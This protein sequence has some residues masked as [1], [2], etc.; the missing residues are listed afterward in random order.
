MASSVWQGL[1]T[2]LFL[3]CFGSFAW[4][5]RRF[6]QQPAGAVP[7]MKLISFCGLVFSILHLIAI[8]LA[9]SAGTRWRTTGAALY[10]CSLLLFWWALSS[11]RKK[12]LSAAFSPDAPSH[13]VQ[14]G[15]YRFIRHPFYTSYLLAWTAGVFAA[16]NLWLIPTVLVML[17]IYL[18][19]ARFEEAK[20]SATALGPEYS[21]YRSSTGL[22]IPNPFKHFSARRDRRAWQ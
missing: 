15:P 14:H 17:V 1:L 11:N 21:S 9:S 6:F 20:F 4:G 16:A 8:L 22:F 19:A 7:G 2:I 10:L 3:L 18:R 5:M 12:P 13:L